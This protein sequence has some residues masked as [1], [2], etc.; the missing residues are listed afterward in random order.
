MMHYTIVHTWSL[1][2]LIFLRKRG[3]RWISESSKFHD[4]LADSN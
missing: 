3:S 2:I 1:V 4:K